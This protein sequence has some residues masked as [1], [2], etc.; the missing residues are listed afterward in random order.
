L[1]VASIRGG[2]GEFKSTKTESERDGTLK[3]SAYPFL[4][5]GMDFFPLWAGGSQREP[6]TMIQVLLIK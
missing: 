1:R 6:F 3:R 4:A 5:L 2:S